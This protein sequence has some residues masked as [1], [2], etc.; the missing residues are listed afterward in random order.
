MNI[1]NYTTSVCAAN[2]KLPDAVHLWILVAG[3]GRGWIETACGRA[4]HWGYMAASLSQV[5]HDKL[6]SICCSFAVWDPKV[7]IYWS[8]DHSPPPFWSFR[9]ECLVRSWGIGLHSAPRIST[10]RC[11][12]PSGI[13]LENLIPS[14]STKNLRWYQS[15][16]MFFLNL[17]QGSRMLERLTQNDNMYI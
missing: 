3:R 2:A 11:P 13:S 7:F 5:T 10:K 15:C 8:L 1:G 16:C 12:N 6:C 17:W 9:P 14:R 4:W